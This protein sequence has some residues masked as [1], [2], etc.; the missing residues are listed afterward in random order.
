MTGWNTSGSS[1]RTV[2]E[3]I[4]EFQFVRRMGGGAS[5]TQEFEEAATQTYTAGQCVQLSTDG[6]IE[7]ATSGGA[8]VIGVAMRAATGVT[9]AT[10]EII[11]GLQ[12]VIFLAST[13]TPGNVAQS[14]VG[15]L[16]DLEIVA[17]VHL[18]NEDASADDVFR[19]VGLPVGATD[20]TDEDFGKVYVQVNSS[21]VGQTSEV[22]I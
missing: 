6:L 12:D 13:S 20:S 14:L 9:N 10:A 4:L 11:L 21:Q 16:V 17:G 15:D 1:A 8:A 18:V 22:A 19:I 3:I 5:P 2:D 7:E